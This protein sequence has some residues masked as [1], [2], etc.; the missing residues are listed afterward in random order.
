MRDGPRLTKFRAR[1]VA[2]VATAIGAAGLRANAQRAG[3]ASGAPTSENAFRFS[4]Q[5]RGPLHELWMTSLSVKQE[6]VACLGGRID[7]DVVYITRI[8]V[9]VPS[10][11]DSA[12]IS[13]IA[14]LR[15]CSA[16]NW[17]GTVHTHIAQFNG[18]PYTIFSA[19]DRYVMTL[20]RERWK[21]PGVFCI[22]Y[23]DVDATCELG[24]TASGHVRYE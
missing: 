18:R 5:V 24:N 15:E 6:R 19:P 23:S 13:A 22:L 17:L 11:A 1:M 3:S 14:S 4:A 10:R 21:A 8:A 12:N 20:W 7:H 2:I 9:L 16:P